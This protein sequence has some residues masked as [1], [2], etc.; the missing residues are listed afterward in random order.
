M[1]ANRPVK[2]SAIKNAGARYFGHAENCWSDVILCKKL[3]H[4]SMRMPHSKV[5]VLEDK[6][7]TALKNDCSE[8]IIRERESRKK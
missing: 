4:T 3:I 1:A 5:G 7:R 8:E 2:R 6:L